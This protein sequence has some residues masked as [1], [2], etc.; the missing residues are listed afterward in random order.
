MPF[1]AFYY[2]IN[3]GS[4]TSPDPGQHCDPTTVYP[5]PTGEHMEFGRSHPAMATFSHPLN[6]N[7]TGQD[8]DNKHDQIT[9]MLWDVYRKKQE[10]EQ[11]QCTKAAF[12]NKIA[13]R[14]QEIDMKWRSDN[15]HATMVARQEMDVETLAKTKEESVINHDN[16]ATKDKRGN[17]IVAAEGGLPLTRFADDHGHDPDDE[18]KKNI[19]HKSKKSNPVKD[20]SP[21]VQP[22]PNKEDELSDEQQKLLSLNKAVELMVKDKDLD[23][24]YI[25]QTMLDVFNTAKANKPNSAASS[26][27]TPP[28]AAAPANVKE[29]KEETVV[30]GVTKVS[31]DEAS[32]EESDDHAY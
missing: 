4:Y 27:R 24:Q 18:N 5:I 21:D 25:L 29:E 12:E 32:D 22:E 14:R 16:T 19:K 13:A 20:H 1:P 31:V 23:T 6:L 7:F 26:S 9:P 8:D 2:G 17:Y 3:K 30:P 28:E 11:H 15:T 10:E